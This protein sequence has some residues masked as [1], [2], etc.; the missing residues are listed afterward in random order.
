MVSLATS[1]SIYL[2]HGAAHDFFNNMLE[3]HDA[4]FDQKFYAH[5]IFVSK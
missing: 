1:G 3:S 5:N 4:I 2:Q